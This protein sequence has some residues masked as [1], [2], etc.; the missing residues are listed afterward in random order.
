MPLV[1]FSPGVTI[2]VDVAAWAVVHTASGYAAHRIP[3]SSLQ[4]DSWLTRPRAC[5]RGG[6]VYEWT[7]IKRWKDRL[8]EAG[9]LFAG[10]VS[11]RS[12]PSKSA[13]GLRRLAVE[14]RRAEVGHCL[15]AVA[16]PLFFLWN[17]PL[18]G[19]AMVVYGIGVN[20]PFIAIQRYNRLRIARALA[21]SRNSRG[22]TGNNIP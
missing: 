11:K 15:A 14:T 4:R 10:G 2:A 22:T 13:D 18:V 20:A 5:E 1:H 3:A 12:L 8:P 16:S 17:S 9:D 7:G 21:R 6:R 19:V